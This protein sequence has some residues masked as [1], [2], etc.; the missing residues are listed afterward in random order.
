M[1]LAVPGR[2]IE[3]EGKT[4]VVDFGG[5]KREVRLDLLPE[6]KVGDYV[7]VHT[8]FAIERLD[9]K[10]ALEILE[11]WAEVERALEG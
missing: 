6:A 3:I 8:G 9:E 1:C 2:I 7:I 4:A 11:A 5:V 10:R